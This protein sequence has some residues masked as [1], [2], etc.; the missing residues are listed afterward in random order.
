MDKRTHAYKYRCESHDLSADPK[1]KAATEGKSNKFKTY[2]IL[3]QRG[4]H[5]VIREIRAQ[6]R[7]LYQAMEECIQQQSAAATTATIG[8][9]GGGGGTRLMEE[10]SR[11]GSGICISVR[12]GV[13]E[14]QYN[15]FFIPF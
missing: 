5:C 1:T 3:G 10:D 4:R 8:G 12:C 11:E 15:T 6:Q 13:G 2:L 14:L 7:Q 9:G